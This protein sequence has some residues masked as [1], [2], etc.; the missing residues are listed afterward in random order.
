[1]IKKREVQSDRQT[2]GSNLVLKHKRGG[3]YHDWLYQGMNIYGPTRR[4]KYH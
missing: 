2:I 4:F 1:M 3:S